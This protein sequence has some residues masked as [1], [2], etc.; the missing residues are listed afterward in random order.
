ML[1]E[2]PV[3]SEA[4][5]SYERQVLEEHYKLK[6]PVEPITRK[7][8]TGK[9]FPNQALKQAIEAFLRD[10]P[11]AYEEEKCENYQDIIFI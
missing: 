6:G 7:E 3:V 11:W 10:N 5:F 1:M 9:I 2:D 4:G 8:V